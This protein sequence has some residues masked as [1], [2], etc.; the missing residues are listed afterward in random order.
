MCLF[1]IF[2][3]CCCKK[4]TFEKSNMERRCAVLHLPHTKNAENNNGV[5]D[6]IKMHKTI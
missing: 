6:M 3:G 4:S 5:E 2:F 1:R